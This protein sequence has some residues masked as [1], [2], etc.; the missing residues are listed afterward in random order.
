MM[1]TWNDDPK[2]LNGY[3]SDGSQAE[4]RG[5]KWRLTLPIG[6]PVSGTA[7]DEDSA[8]QAVEAAHRDYI[9]RCWPLGALIAGQ[10]YCVPLG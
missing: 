8:M 3:A 4:I 9:C 2:T 10:S 5:K 7:E 6:R 1:F